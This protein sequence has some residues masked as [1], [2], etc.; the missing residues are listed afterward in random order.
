MWVC[1]VVFQVCCACTLAWSTVCVPHGRGNE[2]FVGVIHLDPSVLQVETVSLSGQVGEGNSILISDL[3]GGGCCVGDR[4]YA[5]ERQWEGGVERPVDGHSALDGGALDVH[6]SMSTSRVSHPWIGSVTY[7]GRKQSH[8]GGGG[9]GGCGFHVRGVEGGSCSPPLS[10][11]LG[12][13]E[14]GPVAPNSFGF[15][16]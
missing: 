6:I 11:V 2:I 4:D 12:G 9:W 14:R 7:A 3:T 15:C 10:G 16:P 8:L 5:L 1:A 13:I